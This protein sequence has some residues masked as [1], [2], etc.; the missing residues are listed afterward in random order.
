MNVVGYPLVVYVPASFVPGQVVSAGDLAGVLPGSAIVGVGVPGTPY[1]EVAFEGNVYHAVNLTRFIERCA[2][3][4]DRLWRNE[5]SVARLQ[6]SPFAV[7]AVAV[8]W[9]GGNVTVNETM[10]YRLG[11]WLQTGGQP[12]ADAELAL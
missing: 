12:I 8:Y 11:S 6:V 7:V 5:P 3:A 10:A 4:A 1:I 9:P 2:S